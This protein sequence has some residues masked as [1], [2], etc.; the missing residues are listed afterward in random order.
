MEELKPLDVDHDGYFEI[1]EE[2]AEELV[3]LYEDSANSAYWLFSKYANS[4]D[5]FTR[6]RTS[7]LLSAIRD[8]IKRFLLKAREQVFTSIDLA[9]EAG[10]EEALEE[11]E[12]AGWDITM[13]REAM[14]KAVENIAAYASEMASDS[15][16]A[17]A[18]SMVSQVTQEAR[19]MAIEVSRQASISGRSLRETAGGMDAL[20]IT[21][22]FRDRAS[23]RWP[24]DKY[25]NVL[26]RASQK[27]ANREAK[28]AA[29][30]AAGCDLAMISSHGAP[31]RC[32]PW[33]GQIISLTGATEGYPTYAE[34]RASGDI[35]HP[36]C[37]HRLIPLG[38]HNAVQ[39]ED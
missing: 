8:R 18:S 21:F 11:L 15:L 38:K 37:R 6:K 28:I 27:T 4:S 34:T 7:E 36:N 9:A 33:E 35:W 10:M 17:Q 5:F 19:R 20:A 13:D 3:Q 12:D 16:D 22:T 23:R 26:S 29:M 32:G 39:S 14:E 24:A 2:K 31:D 30:V 1:V 25:L